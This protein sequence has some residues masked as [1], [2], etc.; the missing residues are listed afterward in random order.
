MGAYLPLLAYAY[1]LATSTGRDKGRKRY[2]PDGRKK[3][4]GATAVSDGSARQQEVDP[5]PPLTQPNGPRPTYF[6]CRHSYEGAL[7][8]EILRCAPDESVTSPYPG[9][10]RVDDG[11]SLPGGFDPVYAL[12]VIPECIVVSGESIKSIA[13]EVD[14]AL[15]AGGDAML[16][17]NC[18]KRSLEQRQSLITAP[19]GSLTIHPLV[20]GMCKAQPSPVMHSRATKVC[21]ELLQ[22]HKKVYPAAR[23]SKTKQMQDGPVLEMP[24]GERWL[25]QVMLQSPTLAIAS[26]SKCDHVGP[27]FRAYRPCLEHPLGLAKV[28]I[29]EK[30]PSSAYRKLLEALECMGIAPLPST[31]VVDLGACPGGWTGAI[32]RYFDCR[33]IAIDRSALDPVLMRD[34]R[35]S[36][37][38]GDAFAFE[39]PPN[40]DTWMISDI[41]CYPERTTELL[42][43]WC[44]KRLARVM[45]V[46]MKFQ[47]NEPDFGELHRAMKLV[48]EYPGYKCRVK[49]FFNNKNEVTFMVWSDDRTSILE[50]DR[51]SVGTPMYSII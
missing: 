50:L 15:L 27:G 7:I 44:G 14:R 19:K 43:K 16:P 3:K 23:R 46:T 13:L 17:G 35:V 20:P 32:R 48:K 24:A 9:L 4:R 10:V 49:H 2:K 12:Q 28:D 37:A 47:G 31:T 11:A 40:S 5:L 39:P 38:A 29:G 8:D 26:L 33:V 34:D 22:M 45:I 1:L 51:N 30:M 36:F 21:D 6:T 42:S 41:I 18:D 25:L